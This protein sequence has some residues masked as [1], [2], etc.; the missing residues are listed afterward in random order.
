[1]PPESDPLAPLWRASQAFRLITLAY[2]VTYHWV[3]IDGYSNPRLSWFFIAL[4]AIWTGISALLL[5]NP[6]VSKGWV[7]LADHAV[8]IGLMASTRLVAEPEWYHVHQPLP[9]TLWATNAVIAAAILRGPV[10][11][12]VSGLLIAMV[13][14]AVHGNFAVDIGEDAT[15]PMLVSAGLGLGVAATTSRRAQAQVQQAARLAA[16]T[17]ERERL[18]RQVHD[19]VLQV[20]AYVKRRGHEIGGP[21]TELAEK[22]GEQEVALRVLISEQSSPESDAADSGEVDLRSLLRVHA[23]PSVAV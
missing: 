9:T 10:I 8:V 13:S 6:R 5:T 22:A 14:L 20:L 15:I 16:A 12:V 19:G 17:E 7:V 2:A 23:K 1:M 11:G 21:A 3:S 4:T 18:A